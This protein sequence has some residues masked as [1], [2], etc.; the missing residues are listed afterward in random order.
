MSESRVRRARFSGRHLLFL[1][2]FLLSAVAAAAERGAPADGSE[3]PSGTL[4]LSMDEAVSRAIAASF[5]V[6]RASRNE[7]IAVLRERSAEAGR[8]PRFNFGVGLN[9]AARGTYQATPTFT[10]E[11][12]LSGD[13]RT[14]INVA[15]QV[16]IDVSGALRRQVRQAEI[17]SKI[18]SLD[19]EQSKV[20]VGFEVRAA[21][22]AAWR[23]RETA[24]VDEQVVAAIERLARRADAGSAP[25]IDVELS[26]A[27]QAL[28]AS[29]AAA[30]V[31][32]DNL[33]QWMRLPPEVRLALAPPTVVGPAPDA[34][35]AADGRPDVRQARLRVEQAAIGVKQANDGRRP[36]MALNAYYN[37]AW[38][39]E[40]ALR[41]GDGRTRDQGGV[42]ALNVPLYSFD[43]GH[44]ASARQTARVQAE[45]AQADLEE[46]R[47]RAAHEL[48]QAR[49]ALARAEAR[50]R[51]L[52]DEDQSGTAL[53][54]AE[55][56][57]LAGDG[58]E[59]RALLA[60]VSNARAAWRQ[61][62]LSSLGA[63][64]DKALATLRVERATGAPPRTA[65]QDPEAEEVAS[66][67]AR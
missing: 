8:L 54:Q 5:R 67:R 31:A 12:G 49:A 57:Y 64:A 23:A 34:A 26:A 56:A 2:P 59:R 39:G 48:R 11:Q 29:R 3:E 21:Y 19:A 35:P 33:R 51:A 52:P 45:Q 10:R 55:Q 15:A 20:D 36:S 62:R 43:W 63:R 28:E 42:V 66:D 7:R 18:A 41:P 16:P 44:S 58:E 14:G 24:A 53:R 22:V 32:Q 46:V 25:F 13:F 65:G 50:V 47:E 4:A 60:Q 30:D 37:Q 38:T 17:G 61:A 1:I 6:A 40:T 27:R 9:Q